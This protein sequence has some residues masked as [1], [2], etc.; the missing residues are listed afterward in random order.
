MST[1]ITQFFPYVMP[2]VPGCPRQ[3]VYNAVR[4]A[5]RDFCTHTLLWEE[6][7]ASINAVAVNGTDISFTDDDPDTIAS[8]STDFDAAG[9]TAG[10]II[11]T[12]DDDN[13]GPFT[14]ASVAAN[15][16]TLDSGDKVTAAD[17]GDSIYV[18][19]ASY[20]L[21][22][23]NGDIVGVDHA[24][25]YHTPIDAK[26]ESWL[27]KYD[28]YW[29]TTMTEYP[30]WYFVN[31]DRYIQLVYCPDTALTGGFEVWVN[32]KPAWDATTVE[33]WLYDDFLDVIADG[34]RWRLLKIPNKPWSD[35]DEAELAMTDYMRERNA[36][37]MIKHQG[38]TKAESMV[39]FRTFC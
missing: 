5:L 9:F 22:S 31:Q 21:S 27:D 34:A 23:S 12:S 3:T 37:I 1:N 28:Y 10:Q 16:I 4:W 17:A 8:T 38:L 35:K 26:S 36:A 15:A 2:A 32:L 30:R 39:R 13:P 25:Y 20:A 7:L 11:V 19:A 6:K 33:D 18:G 14:I 24:R 29:R